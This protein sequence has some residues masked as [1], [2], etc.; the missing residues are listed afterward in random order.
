[1]PVTQSVLLK[2]TKIN[3]FFK[4]DSNQTYS[5]VNMTTSNSNPEQEHAI[6]AYIVEGSVLY[7]RFLVLRGFFMCVTMFLLLFWSNILAYFS[8]HIP[9]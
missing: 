1:M 6:R 9:F 4:N 8:S 3:V 2:K 7:E 5:K